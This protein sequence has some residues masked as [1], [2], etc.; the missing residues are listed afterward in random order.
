MKE[1]LDDYRTSFCKYTAEIKTSQEEF[2]V[3]F[4]EKQLPH[5]L[6]FH[7]LLNIPKGAKKILGKVDKGELTYTHVKADPNYYLIK[8][9]I[10]NYKFLREVF[11]H[12]KIE[13]LMKNT[14]RNPRRIPGVRVIIPD[15][16]SKKDMIILGLS[17]ANGYYMP[18]TLFLI[19]C[20]NNFMDLPKIKIENIELSSK[21]I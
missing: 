18:S 14:T 5:L 21:E 3:V 12:R 7:K 13:F 16:I 17:E 6:G 9:R 19:R 4:E 10:N 11:H 15:C 8:N 2:H 1:I 20:P